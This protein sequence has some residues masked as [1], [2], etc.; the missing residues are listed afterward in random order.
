LGGF[1]KVV[2]LNHSYD[3]IGKAVCT[4]WAK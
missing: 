1:L 2:K 3:N 4:K